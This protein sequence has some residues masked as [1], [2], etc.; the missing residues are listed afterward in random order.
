MRLISQ[1]GCID[2]PYETSTIMRSECDITVSGRIF[3]RY[4]TQEKAKEVF[5]KLI[6]AYIGYIGYINTLT[7]DQRTNVLRETKDE[8]ISVYYGVFRFPQDS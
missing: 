2:A 8:D 5:D 1:S 6:D 3:A 7:N 4:S